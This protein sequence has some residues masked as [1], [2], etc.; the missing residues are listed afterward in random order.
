MLAI[1]LGV[2]ALLPH[3][4]AAWADTHY[5]YRS[6]CYISK[7]WTDGYCKNF[8]ILVALNASFIANMSADGKDIRFYAIDNTTQYYYEIESINGTNATIWVN[9]TNV[10][11][12]DDTPFWIYYN[13]SA[14]TPSSSPAN[15]W[16]YGYNAVYHMNTTG[17][18][19]SVYDSTGHGYGSITKYCAPATNTTIQGINISTGNCT[20]YDGSDDG[21]SCGDVNEFGTADFTIELIWLPCQAPDENVRRLLGKYNGVG[22]SLVYTTTSSRYLYWEMWDGADGPL[23]AS[24]SSKWFNKPVYINVHR[25]GN[26]GLLVVDNA[27]CYKTVNDAAGLGTLNSADAFSLGCHLPGPD[28][29]LRQDIEEVRV[30]SIQRNETWCN[31][32]YYS[33]N[34]VSSFLFIGNRQDQPIVT[35]NEIASYDVG[36][37]Y[38]SNTSTIYP[39]DARVNITVNMSNGTTF[40]FTLY[41]KLLNDT[42][43]HQVFN[44]TNVT[45][46]T[47][48]IYY[49]DTFANATVQWYFNITSYRNGSITNISNTYYFYTQSSCPSSSTA[50]A[51]GGAIGIIGLIG[52]FGW[53]L[54]KR[55]KQR[56]Y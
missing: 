22:Y 2:I 26:Y 33:I 18:D 21:H 37:L 34:N 52:L 1:T 29:L 10:Y 42:F 28:F 24:G 7:D 35:Y 40:N 12:T 25:I 50:T 51:V 54:S 4:E 27:Q 44:L 14:S 20:Y 45:A 30:S 48:I 31:T 19:T 56:R 9:I 49:F 11:D 3:S 16:S 17:E 47:T 36:T 55:K 32:T 5:S 39:C 15:V 13:Y 53:I 38:P 46:N 43:F 6:W 41:S 23:T 8:P